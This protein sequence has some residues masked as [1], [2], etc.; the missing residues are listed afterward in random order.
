VSTHKE[1]MSQ[2]QFFSRYFLAYFI[3]FL[4]LSLQSYPYQSSKDFKMVDLHL[5]RTVL[6]A[7]KNVTVYT[8]QSM[9]LSHV[10]PHFQ[11][12]CSLL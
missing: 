9:E 2:S 3:A 12:I 5:C 10:S 4:F 6:G 1:R 11:T 7:S 8:E